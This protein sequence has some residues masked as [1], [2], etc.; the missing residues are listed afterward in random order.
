MEQHGVK[1]AQNRK[2]LAKRRAIFYEYYA[3]VSCGCGVLYTYVFMS[4]APRV[5][6]AFRLHKNCAEHVGRF[7]EFIV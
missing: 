1:L 2:L 6:C 4:G 5:A 7:T 3:F